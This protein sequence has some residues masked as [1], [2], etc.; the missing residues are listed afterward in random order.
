MHED[1]FSFDCRVSSGTY[2][3]A[4]V[5]DICS[6]LCIPGV[7]SRL[8]RTAVDD[9]EISDCDQLSDV[10]AGSFHEHDL[11]D[12]LSKRYQ[13]VEWENDKDIRNGKDI[14]YDSDSRY[15]LLVKNREVLAIYGK[16][17]HCYHCVRGL[18]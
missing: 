16:K 15:L 9:I 8:E 6:K 12:V 2:I 1:G 4:L 3:R 5:R 10:L 17:E 13:T 11:Y 18:W 14:V 7:V